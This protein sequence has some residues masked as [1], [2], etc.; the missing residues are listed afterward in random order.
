[1]STHNQVQASSNKNVVRAAGIIGLGTLASRVLG[2]IRDVVIA[3]VFG[4]GIV[5]QAF[6]VAFKLP[7][8]FRDMLGEGAANS[9][10]VPVLG[11]YARRHK[12]EE[13]WRAVNIVLS[14][15]IIA[16]ACVVL[17][18]VL[19]ADILVRLIA[20]GFTA[21][22]EKL[23]LTVRLTRSL[24][25]YLLLAGIAAYAMGILNTLGHF[26]V[27]A[28]APCL[29][30]IAII[31]ALLISKG[32]IE[33]LAYAVLAGGILQVAVQVP[34]LYRKGLRFRFTVDWKHPVAV[35]VARLMGPRVISSC[36]YQ[37][38][39]FVD[40]IFGSLAWIV[41]QGGVAV[42]YFAYRLIFFPLGLISTSLSQ[43]VLPTFSEQALDEHPARLRNTLSWSM[44]LTFFLL[45]P[46]SVAF[47]ALS[48]PIIEILFGGG[49]FDSEAARVTALTL[50]MY[51]I[52]LPAYGVNRILQSCFFSLKDTRTP[53]KVAALG[54]V[55]NITL[56]TLL[57][58]PMRIAGIALATSVSGV[59]TAGI[60]FNVLRARIGGCQGREILSSAWRVALAGLGMAAACF[61][62]VGFWPEGAGRAYRTV[63]LGVMVCAAGG[64]YLALCFAMSVPELKEALA[65]IRKKR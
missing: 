64:V 32:S 58:F 33:A 7:N 6:V 12:R 1:M 37:L 28:L 38:N 63:L 8:L 49:R 16:L 47:M 51:A 40:T 19:Y 10:F 14:F 13:F 30:N 27:P 48:R 25:P 53:A 54:L 43:A 41:G 15:G 5:S 34:V 61:F 29:L 3:R 21:S 24:F 46:A 17:F 45:V 50:S 2:F 23:E 55:S 31:A 56:N 9:V 39:N 52:G 35:R 4:T 11:E 20:P 65:W 62:L 44:R 42:L 36:L 18:G 57:M 22:A 60:F 59:L 26:T